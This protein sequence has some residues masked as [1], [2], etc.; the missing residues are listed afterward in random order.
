MTRQYI[1]MVL[2]L[3]LLLG[4]AAGCGPDLDESHKG[5]KMANCWAAGCH[6]KSDTHRQ[7]KLPYQC[8][9]CHGANGAKLGH[10]SQTPCTSCHPG[11]HGEVTLFPDPISCQSCHPK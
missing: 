11:K 7:D 2:A 8:A 6:D 3:A 5:W 9:E 10:T 1:K 4:L